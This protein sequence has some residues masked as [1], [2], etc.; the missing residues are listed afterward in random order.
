MRTHFLHFL[1]AATILSAGNSLDCEIRFEDNGACACSSHDTAGP[2]TRYCN[3]DRF[4]KIRPCYC[5]Y[6]DPTQNLSVVGHC[7][8]SCYEFEGT[9]TE[10]TKGSEFNADICHKY[11]HLHRKGRFCG[12]CTDH[13]GFAAYSYQLFS[14]TLCQDYGYKNWLRYFAVALL[15]LTVFYILAVLLSFNVMSS[16]LNGI[17]LVLQCILSP[18]Q[19][20]LVQ[21]SPRLVQYDTMISLLKAATSLICAV[22]LDFF[23]LVYPPFCLHPEA[24][25]FQILSLDYIVALYP[26]LLI[27][28]TYVLVTAYDKQYRLVVW[29]WRPVQW[30]VRRH[31]NTWDIHTS[32]IEIFSTF[33]LFSYVKILDVSVQILN[34]TAT[35]DVAGNRLQHYYTYLDGTM[36]YF[37]TAHLP[38]A[39]LAIAISSV[40]VVLPFLLLAVYP[41]RCF[42]KCL[43]FC[44]LNSQ[45]LTVFMD[46][47][48]GGYRI[49][50][51]DL[52]YFSAFYLLLRI[53]IVAQPCIFPS[54][55][56]LFTSGIP[57]FIAAAMIT[58][59]QPFNV[60]KHNKRDSIM[61]MLL[62]VYFV[63][64]YTQLGTNYE[65]MVVAAAV[66]I[67][68]YAVPVLFFISLLTWKLLGGKLQALL[69]RAKSVWN[70]IAH[71]PRADSRGDGMEAFDREQDT[72][73]TNRYP[74]L[75]GDHR[76]LRN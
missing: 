26:F 49:Q 36:K 40:F 19:I 2:V 31:R 61:M 57:C 15:P 67:V 76:N 25:V 45:T 68:T 4:I 38:Y 30:C 20:T 50:P 17:V 56:L 74:P 72:S 54:R 32:L 48:Q 13:Y 9:V 42:H 5:M 52:R 75:L 65:T 63:C 70:S 51:H 73:E 12:Q 16:N 35:Y 33:I 34:F 10:I 69:V 47:F 6:Y 29:M 62:G 27:F 21:G 7:Y 41:C 22:N 37:G 60:N 3:S 23:R 18:Q 8:F 44:G 55:L 64:Y 39:V 14:C 11:G 43:N 28:M 71:N 1:L 46:A 24:S 66:Q 53:L 58:I 59:F